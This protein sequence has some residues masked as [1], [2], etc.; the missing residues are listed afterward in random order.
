MESFLEKVA[1]GARENF[2]KLPYPNRK[3]KN[4]RFADISSWGAKSL[5]KYFSDFSELCGSAPE[6]LVEEGSGVEILGASE[7]AAKYPEET[8]K[9]FSDPDGKFEALQMCVPESSVLIDVPA[10]SDAKISIKA[11]KM[12][13]LSACGAIVRIGE[14][15]RVKISRELGSG[16]FSSRRFLFELGRDSTLEMGTFSDSSKSAPHFLRE[17]FYCGEG[18]SIFDS[19][20][21]NGSSCSRSERIFEILGE[22]VKVD[23][24]SFLSGRSNITHD[25]RTFQ[26]HRAGNSKSDLAVKAA[27]FDESSLAFSGLV[28][29]EEE[30][31]K[32]DAYQSCNSMLMSSEARSQSEPSLEILSNDVACSHGCAVSRPDENQIFYM[33]SRGISLEVSRSLIL[34][35]FAESVFEKFSDRKFAEK[36]IE[37]LTR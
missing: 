21:E 26:M 9:F 37:A 14:G 28:R 34:R 4:W 17:K 24:R 29:V 10:G 23:S 7:A 11:S 6:A 12:D 36:W 8:G 25:L 20:A 30:A 1:A 35:G 13:S 33:R 22:R 15:A 18:S 27:L 3:D 2:L 19:F 32:T 5:E 16:F 31:R